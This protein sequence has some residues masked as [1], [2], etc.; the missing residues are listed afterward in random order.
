MKKNILLSILAIGAGLA[1]NAQT[2]P[3][4]TTNKNLDSRLASKNASLYTDGYFNSDK[5]LMAKARPF[6]LTQPNQTNVMV[7]HRYW[8]DI[9]LKD[10]K[11]Q[12]FAQPGNS[13][14]EVLLKGIKEGKITAYDATSTASNPTGDAF[15]APLTYNQLMTRL[16]DTALVNKLD[17]DGNIIGTQKMLNDFSPEK[18]TGYRIKEDVYFDKQRAR[19][20]TRIIGI[21]PLERITLSNGDTLST[22]PACWIKFKEARNVFATVNVSDA[23]M[24]MYDVSMDDLFMQRQF[25]AKIIEESNPEGLRIKDYAKTSDEQ[26]KEAQRIENK[27]AMY[28]KTMWNYSTTGMLNGPATNS[29]LI[30]ASPKMAKTAPAMNNNAA[31]ASAD[32][33]SGK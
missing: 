12:K 24:N 14:I 18:I 28:K 22:Q 29:R 1:A 27:L 20:E 16:S 8:R 2:T 25:N 3:T 19:V 32:V 9:D 13:V 6:P 17:K 31:F 23:D 26:A 10:A 21:A 4:D 5:D 11:N 30:K 15:V 7:Y 33:T